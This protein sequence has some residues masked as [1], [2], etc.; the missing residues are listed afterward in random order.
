MMPTLGNEKE[1]SYEDFYSRHLDT[2]PASE[3]SSCR[4][5]ESRATGLF[6]EEEEEEEEEGDFV[7][8]PGEW[9]EAHTTPIKG[10]VQLSKIVVKGLTDPGMRVA[11]H[12][13]KCGGMVEIPEFNPYLKMPIAKE[14]STAVEKVTIAAGKAWW[15]DILS[16]PRQDLRGWLLHRSVDRGG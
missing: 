12:V 16:I 2:P 11:V 4:F 10:E 15:E 6:H 3:R 1:D 5:G 9:L 14:A 13:G 8:V 7:G